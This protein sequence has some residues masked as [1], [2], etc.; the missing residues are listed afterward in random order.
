MRALDERHRAFVREILSQD[1]I[2]QG[3]AA[4]AA[5]FIPRE[6]SA[7]KNYDGLRRKTGSVL[8]HK[9]LVQKAI[10]EVGGK[11]LV[12]LA[13]PAIMA[14]KRLVSDPSAKGHLGA[15]STVLD[16]VGFGAEQNINVKHEHTDMTG[17]AMVERIRALAVK[18]GLDPQQFL[19]GVAQKPQMKVIEHESSVPAVPVT[20]AVP[21]SLR[22][23]AGGVLADGPDGEDEEA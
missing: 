16:R 12:A 20:A 2:D 4:E 18:H 9:P 23:Q 1:E 7:S 10:L 21:S 8:M 13:L 5:G 17:A 15:V 3:R 11:E 22:V 6:R 19:G 14:M